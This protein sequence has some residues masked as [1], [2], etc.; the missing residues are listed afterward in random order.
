MSYAG[1]VTR[2]Q[3]PVAIERRN[4]DRMALFAAGVALGVTVGAGAALILA[5]QSGAET[6]QALARRGRRLSRRGRDAW[7]DLR[8]EFRRMRRRRAQAQVEAEVV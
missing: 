6:R 2:P 7:D 1:P 8:L 4:W 5:P 3:R